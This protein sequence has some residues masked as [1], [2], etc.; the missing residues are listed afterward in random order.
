M[1]LF[2][3]LPQKWQVEPV[4]GRFLRITATD[5][6]AVVETWLEEASPVLIET[7]TNLQGVV[8]IWWKGCRRPYRFS[9]VLASVSGEEPAT[10]LLT[11]ANQK[12]DKLTQATAEI[13]AE[14][15]GSDR[16]TYL[17]S[18]IDQR[19]LWLNGAALAA[20][21][22]DRA[23]KIIGSPSASLWKPESFAR[24]LE[25]LQRDRHIPEFENL[26]YQWQGGDVGWH[27]KKVA[28]VS[29]YQ[30]VEWLGEP[31]RVCQTL[32]SESV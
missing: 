7:A 9:S 29:D 12:I 31:C 28:T 16:P 21:Q 19:I 8:E 27:R 4:D 5:P 24:M 26:G 14:F 3:Y 10:S 2:D 1:E 22:L 6:Q 18:M 23:G 32:S 20:N 17:T 11:T 30:W 13:I 25:T 15:A